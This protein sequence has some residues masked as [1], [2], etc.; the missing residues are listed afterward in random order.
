MRTQEQRQ[1]GRGRQDLRELEAA[2]GSRHSTVWA[3]NIAW[4]SDGFDACLILRISRKNQD[5]E[6]LSEG[7]EEVRR[8]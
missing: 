8:D 5:L 2:A 3:L 7:H 1:Q 6:G 4:S